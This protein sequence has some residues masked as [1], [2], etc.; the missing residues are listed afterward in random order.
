MT[1][2][3]HAAKHLWHGTTLAPLLPTVR[4]EAVPFAATVAFNHQLD[5]QCIEGPAAVVAEVAKV[6]PIH[7]ATINF[8]PLGF[9]T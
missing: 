4:V 6:P 3:G 2:N 9:C 7:R 1:V 5:A 8:A